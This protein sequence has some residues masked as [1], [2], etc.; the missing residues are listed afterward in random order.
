MEKSILEG[1]GGPINATEGTNNVAD[2]GNYNFQV[3]FKALHNFGDYETETI[4]KPGVRGDNNSFAEEQGFLCNSVDHWFAIRKVHGIW[5]NLNSTNMDP[6]PQIIS[7]F[8]LDAFLAAVKNSGYTI[9]VIRGQDLPIPH[10]EENQDSL[11]ENQRYIGLEYLKYHHENNKHKQLNIDGA[12][13]SEME[14]A[15]KASLDDMNGQ[16]HNFPDQTS[17]SQDNYNAD[18]RN[19]M[20]KPFWLIKIGFS[21]KILICLSIEPNEEDEELAK[22]IAL[23]LQPDNNP[24]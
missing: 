18:L 7:D 13:Q 12:D 4:D 3:L 6:G 17:H 2:D 24:Q 21:I 5:F 22:A 10:K 11:R 8:Y 16:Q 1:D 23:S 20:S 19:N 15:I 14:A 9:F